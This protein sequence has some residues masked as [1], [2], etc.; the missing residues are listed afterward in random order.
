M[1]TIFPTRRFRLVAS[2][3]VQSL[4]LSFRRQ[5]DSPCIGPCMLSPCRAC[6]RATTACHSAHWSHDKW[7]PV[8][9]YHCR[10][11]NGKRPASAQLDGSDCRPLPVSWHLSFWRWFAHSKQ[12]KGHS[13]MVSTMKRSTSAYASKLNMLTC[14]SGMPCLLWKVCSLV[15]GLFPEWTLQMFNTLLLLTICSLN[16]CLLS[17]FFLVFLLSFFHRRHLTISF[18]AECL[19]TNA[20]LNEHVC[21]HV[22]LLVCVSFLL[23]GIF[24]DS[25]AASSRLKVI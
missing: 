12:I 17:Y 9:G 7:S 2:Q 22:D 23:F 1:W 19:F 4:A 3:A 11:A 15:L 10:C 6:C 16:I 18:D 8:K 14:N 20:Y 21:V 25:M 24:F 13:T 5:S